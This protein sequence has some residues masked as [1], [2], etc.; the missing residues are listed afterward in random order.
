VDAA[1]I[2][3]PVLAFSILLEPKKIY[4]MWAVVLIFYAAWPEGLY[5]G[6][7]RLAFNLPF[8]YVP[9]LGVFSSGALSGLMRNGALYRRFPKWLC[10]SAAGIILYG[11]A[12]ALWVRDYTSWFQ[13]LG[14]WGTYIALLFLVIHS[15]SKETPPGLSLFLDRMLF[16]LSGFLV[17]VIIRNLTV[18]A[19]RYS[20]IEEFGLWDFSP[21]IRYRIS[22][23]IAVLPFVPV[24]AMLYLASKQIRYLLFVGA[25]AIAIFASFS[26]DGIIGLIFS[27]LL[28][29][30]LGARGPG[31]PL[32]IRPRRVV[33]IL[34]VLLLGVTFAFSLGRANFVGR[35]FSVT[36]I[37]DIW[38]GTLNP[39]EPL[40][41]RMVILQ[42]ATEVFFQRPWLGTGM[43][44]Y[45]EFLGPVAEDLAMSPHNLY[46]TYLSEF[47][48]IGF[49]PLMA[50]L[51]GL[52]HFLWKTSREAMDLRSRAILQGLF[53]S[54]LTFFVMFFATDFLVT[55][56]VWFFWGIALAFGL[57]VG[58]TSKD[59]MPISRRMR[60]A[61]VLLARPAFNQS[62]QLRKG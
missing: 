21:M 16:L 29:A 33:A 23:I 48:I 11:L 26:R 62:S 45:L 5:S 19:A 41:G 59:R 36:S 24:A 50:F 47:G 61:P 3:L 46:V 51:V 20:G 6:D 18:P 54:Q 9:L 42:Q 58:R 15:L 12:S 52:T 7:Q 44:N 34:L 55:P 43:G 22:Q 56:Y 30:I 13:Y 10:F 4:L 2:L 27:L 57:S 35:V 1:F 14:M 31:K 39:N 60:M 37:A 8:E 40:W 49:I 17:I 28:C 32:V 38:G 53:F 25:A